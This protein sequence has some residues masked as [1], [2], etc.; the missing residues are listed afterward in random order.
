MKTTP[1]DDGSPPSSRDSSPV[2]AYARY[3]S[4][5]LQFTGLLAAFVFGGYWLDDR[6]GWSPWGTLLGTGLGFAGATIWL[7][8]ELYSKRGSAGRGS[9]SGS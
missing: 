2:S 1:Q 9:A 5:G 8:R 7:Y 6:Y 3:S 4:L